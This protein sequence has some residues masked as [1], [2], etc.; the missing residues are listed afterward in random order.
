VMTGRWRWADPS[1]R[2]LTARGCL[3]LFI[4]PHE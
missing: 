4:S 2:R 3:L 1:I